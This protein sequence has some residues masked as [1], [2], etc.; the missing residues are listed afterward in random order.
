[1]SGEKKEK[2]FTRKFNDLKFVRKIQIGFILIAAIS[3]FIAVNDY[4]Q[5][6]K[7]EDT[8][9]ALFSD[10][11]NP[12]SSI[13]ELYTRFQKVQFIM[14]KFSMP[15][16]AD[17][18]EADMKE[19]QSQKAAFDTL[20]TK[21]QNAGFNEEINKNL[22]DIKK[23]WTDY[24]NVV[25]DAIVSAAATKS[26]EMAGIIATSSGTE[27][28]NQ[29]VTKFDHITSELQNTADTLDENVNSGVRSAKLWIF[30]GMALGTLV[31]LFSSF[32]IA[33]LIT[34][35]VLQLKNVI[36]EFALGDYDTHIGI[37]SKDEVGQLA[38]MMRAL[39]NVQS[40]KVKAA[41]AIAEGS[42]EKVTPA[43]EKDVLAHAFN[44]EINTMQYLRE[45][46]AKLIEANNRGDLSIRGDVNKFSGGWREFIT[47]MN[48][49]VEAIIAP[50][51]EAS[52]VLDK[53]AKG[54]FTKRMEGDYKGD[55]EI[56]KNN[57]NKV[58]DSLN[59]LLGQV[60][61]STSELATAAS[62]I[63]SSTEEMAAGASEQT[64]QTEEIASSVEEMTRTILDS[65]RNAQT[66]ANTAK[67]NGEKAKDGGKVVIET[68]NG[69]NR[70]AEVVVISADTIKELGKSSDQI[71]EII[72]VINEI[73][74]QTNLLALNA[75]IEAARAGEQ[76]RGFAVVADEVR[77]LAERTTKAT[78]EIESMIKRIQK[79]TGSA[80][81]A[82]Q[83]GTTEVQ[84]G[85]ELAQNAGNSLNE[86]ITN[87][88][89]VA[90]LITQLAAA[91]EQQS[92]TSEQISRNIEAINNVTQQAAKGTEQISHTAEG[93]YR[94]TENLQ[95]ILES[96]K[97][98]YSNGAVKKNSKSML[99]V[100]A[101]GKIEKYS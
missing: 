42:F 83:E 71:G 74:E 79:D 48:S 69:I 51:N 39:R 40:E 57:V 54:D 30:I 96:F 87:S 52:V 60:T 61:E 12:R 38:D 68:I 10:Y 62:Q 100:R 36:S 16:F 80:V 75:A 101:N 33:P 23:V 18:F 22:G 11:I 7:F 73:A 94:L 4:M 58:V 26:Y 47:G 21:L 92:A 46:T 98:D 59:Q 99:S 78:K 37:H 2:I 29:L 32:I 89:K 55:Y 90:D 56:I 43:S 20:L 63:S 64:S 6:N 13:D 44:T 17:Q 19:Y 8:K 27:V 85:K 34:K 15:A 76:G 35:P 25:A 81:S 28:G 50:I 53:M 14:M 45:E 70:I 67:Q 77:K 82:I 3:A 72:L 91:S 95:S 65:T 41:K 5:M 31:F 66:A 24:K 93:L 1:M 86:I 49:I 84:K 97:L 88:D 9:N